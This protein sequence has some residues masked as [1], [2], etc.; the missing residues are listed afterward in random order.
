MRA[1]RVK[2]VTRIK[3]GLK[4]RRIT[5]IPAKKKVRILLSLI[6]KKCLDC[7][8]YQ[9]EEIKH[10]PIKKCSLY[11]YRIKSFNR[12]KK[13]NPSILITGGKPRRRR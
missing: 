9:P 11:K 12:L 5:R 3:K 2:Q 7:S 13:D 8:N 10:C 6:G 4:E 1:S